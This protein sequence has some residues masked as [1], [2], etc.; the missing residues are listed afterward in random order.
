MSA[1]PSSV[2]FPLCVDL[3][4]TL[5][6][7]DTMF[8]S[9]LGCARRRP[10]ALARVPLW[11]MQG[12]PAL[13]AH[14]QEAAPIDPVALPYREDVLAW[15]ASERE[16]GRHVVLATAS[17]RGVADAMAEHLGLFDEVLATEGDCNLKG[18]R[19]REA[20][21]ERFGVR[22]YEY[23]GDS[24]ADLAVW[25]G[26]ARA[27]TVGF[28]RERI[29][30]RAP[31]GR[32]FD[33]PRGGI[34]A[35]V[36]QL[37]L[38]Q[39]VKNVLIFL[40]ALAAHRITEP[41]ILRDALLAFLAFGLTASAVYVFN[42]LMDL[43]SDRAH[44][45]KR[46]R[47]FASGRLSIVAGLLVAPLLV[48]SA[49]WLASA[50]LPPRFQA[51]LGVYLLLNLI[52]TFGLKRVPIADVIFLASLYSLRILAGGFATGVS[53]S[54]WLIAF[55]L[56]FFLNLALLKRYADLRI[57]A[58]AGQDA[59]AGRGYRVAD[60]PW[61]LF[62]GPAAGYMSAAVLA[63]YI[64]SDKVVTLYREPAALWVLVPLLAYW[65]TRVW[66]VAHRGGMTDD[67]IVF[68]TR[69]PGSYAVLGL[70]VVTFLVGALV[71]F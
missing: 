49:L 60:A 31:A 62:V 11:L 33:V 61:I 65:I 68:T 56:F 46:K 22:G 21:D 23:L 4:G 9:L 36:R 20:L 43:P 42:D 58:A 66:L 14:L 25:E 27:S 29:G 71:T 3:D 12:R 19:K 16:R 30:D 55:S 35:W 64:Q 47:P 53:V 54:P 57:L 2:D 41:A 32:H 50:A 10:L 38:H 37:R 24:R 26:A 39:W 51:A 13:K 1:D 40:P 5:I 28:A 48:L 8:E 44:P 18:A 59:A 17:D 69:D 52:Y 45:E 67:P 34:S 7:S 70:A 63:L 6:A 15:V